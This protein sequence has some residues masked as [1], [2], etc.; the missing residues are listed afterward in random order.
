MISGPGRDANMADRTLSALSALALVCLLVVSAAI[1][2]E[3]GA[4]GL[5]LVR[6]WAG[7]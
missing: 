3:F 2:G 7:G 6:A 1:W 5:T 4:F